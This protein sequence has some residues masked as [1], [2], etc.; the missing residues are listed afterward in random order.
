MSKLP[1]AAFYPAATTNLYEAHTRNST[2]MQGGGLSNNII[3]RTTPAVTPAESNNISSPVVLCVDGVL[4]WLLIAWITAGTAAIITLLIKSCRNRWKHVEQEEFDWG[5][6]ERSR[7]GA[8]QHTRSTSCSS[9]PSVRN[10]IPTPK[11]SVPHSTPSRFKTSGS[12][13]R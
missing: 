11:P 7:P 13:R 4:L 3:N 6:L 10:A 9:A 5:G 12:R 8:S 1:I 2:R